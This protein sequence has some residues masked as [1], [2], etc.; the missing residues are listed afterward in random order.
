MLMSVGWKLTD[1]AKTVTTHR[2]ATLAAATV[3][4]RSTAMHLLA[5]VN[6]TLLPIQRET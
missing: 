6:A 2:E 4:T 5:M 1:A 3:D